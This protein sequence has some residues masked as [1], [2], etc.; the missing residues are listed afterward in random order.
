[1]GIRITKILSVHQ[2]RIGS[3]AAANCSK[4]ILEALCINFRW[5][6]IELGGDWDIRDA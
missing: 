6:W 5:R 3:Y 2:L 1:M 4:L